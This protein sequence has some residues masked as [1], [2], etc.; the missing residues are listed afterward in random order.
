MKKA[1]RK[2]MQ[3]LEEEILSLA[4]PHPMNCWIYDGMV[5]LQKLPT[6]LAIFGNVSDY[7]LNKVAVSTHR[8]SFFDTDQYDQL[9]IR[10]DT[11][12]ADKARSENLISVQE[13]SCQQ[14]E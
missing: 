8:I 7:L 2:F 11:V 10:R 6:Q 3:L 4:T 9:S 13:V 5:L 14:S 12:K 1:K